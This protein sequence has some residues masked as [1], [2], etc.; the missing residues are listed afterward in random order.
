MDG[1]IKRGF[2]KEKQPKIR[3]NAVMCLKCK[4]VIQSTHVHDFVR[5]YCGA[6][7]VDGGNEYLKRSGELSMFKEMSEYHD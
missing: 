5:C 3:R 4:S 2:V 1:H 7:A 6:V